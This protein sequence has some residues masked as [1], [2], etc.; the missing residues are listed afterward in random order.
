MENTKKNIE[1]VTAYKSGRVV[2]G[3]KVIIAILFVTISYLLHQVKGVNL[4]MWYIGG[5]VMVVI[6]LIRAF[7]I[8]K[9]NN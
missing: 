2:M 1:I 8:L 3:A 5:G 7:L 9:S 4:W 6:R